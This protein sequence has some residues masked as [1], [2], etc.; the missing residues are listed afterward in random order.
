MQGLRLGLG[1][2]SPRPTLEIFSIEIVFFTIV[3]VLCML[4]YF[5]T[6]DIYDL[7]G[8]KGVYFFINIFLFFFLAYLFRLMLVTVFI[9]PQLVSHDFIIILRLVSFMLV[10]YTSIMVVASMVLS[11]HHRSIRMN[12]KILN[13]LVHLGAFILSVAVLITGSQAIMIIVLTA[14][15][16]SSIVIVYVKSDKLYSKNRLTYLMLGIF[17]IISIVTAP[18]HL[19]N[20]G[21]K[22]ILYAVSIYIFFSIYFRLLKRLSNEKG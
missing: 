14:V 1:M 19:L 21:V 7:T 17:W 4:I 10:S 18:K 12:E 6:K 2:G 9:S 15:L 3:A 5:R 11:I 22:V 16:L 8:H 20:P 13:I